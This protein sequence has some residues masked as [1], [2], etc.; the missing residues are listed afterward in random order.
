MPDQNDVSRRDFMQG[1]AKAAGVA[2]GAGALAQAANAD[3][4]KRILPQ[5]VL[6]ANEKLLSGHIGVGQMGKRDL[7]F[8]MLREDVQ[9]VAVCDLFPP[10]LDQATQIISAKYPEP[11]K[12]TYFEEVIANKDIDIIVVVTPDHWHTVPTLMAF[13]AGKDVYCEKPMSTTIEEGQAI[14]ASAKEHDRIYQSGTMQR[15]GVYFQEAVKMV[16]DGYIGKIGRVETFNYDT[17]TVKGIGNP[18]DE[19]AP[20]WLDWERYVGWT[21]T[22]PFNKNRF[23]YNF[24]WFTEYSGGKITDWGAHLLDIAIWAMGEDKQPKAVTAG[25][26]NFV[27]EDNRTTPDTLNVSW[28]FDNYLLTFSNMAWNPYPEMKGPGHGI[29]FHGTLGSML[30]DRRGYQVFPFRDNGGCE[31]VSKLDAREMDMNTGHWENFIQCVRDHK[32]TICNPEVAYNTIRT[33]VT[34]KAAYLANAKLQWDALAQK[35]KGGDPDAVKVG[36]EWLYK[37]YENGW[38]LKAPHHPNLKA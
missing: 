5:T 19:P 28:E 30:V 7:Q 6:G 1:A 10:N 36:N 11:T 26:G 35:F 37:P 21:R 15:S 20:S 29:Y 4:Y 32:P 33:C 8:V 16:Q 38:S 22:V 12:H 17:G 27:L 2:A 3:V 34:G 31:P 18:P 24:R 13:E 14:V 23:Q 25:G 9:P